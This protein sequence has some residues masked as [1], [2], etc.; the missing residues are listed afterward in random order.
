MI[1]DGGWKKVSQ[2]RRV[3]WAEEAKGMTTGRNV[4]SVG[5]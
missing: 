2:K 3:F 4:S 1:L 5:N